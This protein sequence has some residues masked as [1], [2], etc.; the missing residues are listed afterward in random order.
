M[1]NK[2]F[3]LTW[4]FL[5]TAFSVSAQ[6]SSGGAFELSQSVIAGGG[7]TNAAGGTFT[8][9][10][11]IGE[12]I[13]GTTSTN[14]PYAVRGGFLTAAPLAPTAASVMISGRVLTDNGNGLIKA[15]V[16]LTAPNGESRTAVTTLS[17]NYSFADV[18]VGETY[19]ISIISKRYLFAPQVVFVGD[20]IINL[21]F[22]ALAARK[23]LAVSPKF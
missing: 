3:I 8:L 9:D 7:V 17:G 20:E 22:T 6:I 2:L 5:L 21:D 12:A 19:I 18:R 10:S 11:T 13:A 16:V 23:N 4:M 15:R 1:K 14:S